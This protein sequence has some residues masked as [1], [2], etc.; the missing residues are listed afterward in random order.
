MARIAM[1]A[2]FLECWRQNENVHWSSGA[3]TEGRRLPHATVHG[4]IHACVRAN[5]AGWQPTTT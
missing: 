2:G 1:R 4:C 5:L 3:R